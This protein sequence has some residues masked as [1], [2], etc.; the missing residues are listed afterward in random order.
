[1]LDHLVYATPTLDDTV[2]ALE[3]ALGV[4]PAEGG[5]HLGLGTRNH[6]LG[7]GGPRYLEIVGRTRSSRSRTGRAGS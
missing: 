6:L 5:R 4:R 2:A 7:L 3:K 1:M